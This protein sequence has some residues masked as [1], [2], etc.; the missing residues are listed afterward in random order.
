MP[1]MECEL[2]VVLAGKVE[3]MEKK[4]EGLERAKEELERKVKTMETVMK[5]NIVARLDNVE[6][7]V[8]PSLRNKL[9]E[10]RGVAEYEDSLPQN[11]KE[12]I[13]SEDTGEEEDKEVVKK[14]DDV[15]EAARAGHGEV[16]AKESPAEKEKAWTL[17]EL[18][19]KA[20]DTR[21]MFG[22]VDHRYP[23]E[24]EVE[25]L[26]SCPSNG[27]ML[28]AMGSSGEGV[29]LC[30]SYQKR[31]EEIAMERIRRAGPKWRSDLR[32]KPGERWVKRLM[33]EEAEKIRV[34]SSLM[35]L[36]ME[37]AEERGLRV[38]MEE[39]EYG[40]VEENWEKGAENVRN[41]FSKLVGWTQQT[42]EETAEQDLER[43]RLQVLWAINQNITDME[44]PAA[45]AAATGW[46]VLVLMAGKK[47]EEV[48]SLW[49]RMVRHSIALILAGCTM[50][51]KNS[52]SSIGM[53]I[54]E[55]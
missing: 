14:E 53:M 46:A 11:M 8:V 9:A 13:K 6:E 20:R 3:N 49:R 30:L 42:T 25:V 36:W 16:I 23:R 44:V 31:I 41:V 1:S 51:G 37:Q 15:T 19:K 39:P 45:Q 2:L 7:V 52:V 33:V 24:N 27:P 55:Y 4:V 12:N 26:K 10:V 32:S 18:K 22:A 40:Q 38:A 34:G 29:W 21:R 43:A 47:E 48:N 5:E 17:E 28:R 54:N 50:R 35:L